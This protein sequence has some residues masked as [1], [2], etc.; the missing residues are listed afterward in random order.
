MSPNLQAHIERFIQ[1]LKVECLDRFV[2]VAERH[3]SYVCREWRRH[4][5]GERPHSA[6]K[7]LPPDIPEPQ[8][9]MADITSREI[10]CTTRL[11]GL[12]KSYAQRAA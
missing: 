6:K 1:S 8:N 10:V 5:N 9:Q 7:H 12:L 4:Y 2:I 3:L 11:G